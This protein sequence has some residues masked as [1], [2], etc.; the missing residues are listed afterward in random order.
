MKTKRETE[1][2]EGAL[3]SANGGPVNGVLKPLLWGSRLAPH[4]CRAQGACLQRERKRETET[5]RQ[6]ERDADAPSKAKVDTAWE[7]HR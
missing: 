3:G 6:R 4:V 7:R 1:I 5:E 2:R